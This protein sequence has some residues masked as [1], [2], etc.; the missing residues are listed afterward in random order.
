MDLF[1]WRFNQN[2]M[3]KHQCF[4]R[5]LRRLYPLV[6]ARRKYNH[7]FNK[8][9]PKKPSLTLK[10][11]W[12]ECQMMQAKTKAMKLSITL[13]IPTASKNLRTVH[14]DITLILN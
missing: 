10:A 9:P 13:L 4:K 6:D 2:L 7:L 8:V 3:Q 1:N 12:K 5:F 14:D 11:L